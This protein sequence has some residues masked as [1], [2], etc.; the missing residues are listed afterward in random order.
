MHLHIIHREHLDFPD[1]K[2]LI[3]ELEGSMLCMPAWV[4][5]MRS[6]VE[7]L[8][9]CTPAWLHMTLLEKS[10]TDHCA[11]VEPHQCSGRPETSHTKATTSLL[12]V[13]STSWLV[14]GDCLLCLD[15]SAHLSHNGSNA[16]VGL[17][18]P[19]SVS[20]FC[21]DMYGMYHTKGLSTPA[22]CS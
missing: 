7:V 8:M 12:L 4:R 21:L 10:C 5:Y 9:F 1:R 16:V 14:L 6:H 13:Y 2:H 3:H 20:S 19:A 18:W 22:R 17:T 15:C 11:D